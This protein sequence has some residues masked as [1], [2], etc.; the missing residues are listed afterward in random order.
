MPLSTGTKLGPYQIE[1]KLGEGGMGEVYR[2]L[3]TGLART[4][5]IKVL[6]AGLSADADRRTRFEREARAIAALSHPHFCT[7]YDV[8]DDQGRRTYPPAR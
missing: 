7:L 6:P 2:A 5:A 4:V 8:G 1:A 3:D